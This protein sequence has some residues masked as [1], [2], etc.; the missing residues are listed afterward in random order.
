MDAI[1]PVDARKKRHRGGK[2]YI[3]IPAS[4]QTLFEHFLVRD[5]GAT[6]VHFCSY[7]T[8]GADEFAGPA[9]NA[10]A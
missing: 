6:A 10:D 9:S 1:R 2:R 4:A 3:Y 7:G 8:G 5:R